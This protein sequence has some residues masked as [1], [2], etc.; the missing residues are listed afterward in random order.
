LAHIRG[1]LS[2]GT[3]LKTFSV[4]SLS[5]ILRDSYIKLLWFIIPYKYGCEVLFALNILNDVING[6]VL[7]NL[8]WIKKVN[9]TL[10]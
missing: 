5:F 3:H 8:Y 4:I 6:D 7:I 10:Q 9:V 1:T 2:S